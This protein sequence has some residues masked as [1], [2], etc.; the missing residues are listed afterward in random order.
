MVAAFDHDLTAPFWALGYRWDI[1]LGG[2]KG[3][4][5]E[6]EDGDA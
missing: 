6:S 1:I 2:P 5:T 4:W 3:T